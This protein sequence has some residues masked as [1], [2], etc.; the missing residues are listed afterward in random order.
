[1]YLIFVAIHRYIFFKS[2]SCSLSSHFTCSETNTCLHHSKSFTCYPCKRHRPCKMKL[3]M[4]I[5]RI[6][7]VN[8]MFMQKLRWNV[9]RAISNSKV[10]FWWKR[11]LTGWRRKS[12]NCGVSH[13][14]LLEQPSRNYS[15]QVI[16]LCT[17]WILKAESFGQKYSALKSL[18]FSIVRLN[19]F[20][21]FSPFCLWLH[22]L[23][24]KQIDA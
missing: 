22:I 9:A 1:M 6:Q 14:K 5:R 3:S 19:V 12:H 11:H 23:S 2:S 17:G 8:K 13:A 10:P 16:T 20:P 4:I 7:Y 21:H 24:S 15:S 18:V